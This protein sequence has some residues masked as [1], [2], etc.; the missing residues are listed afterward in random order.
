MR[1][2]L[3]QVPYYECCLPLTTLRHD[4]SDSCF[5][6][7]SGGILC[8][9]WEVRTSCHR[10][11]NQVLQAQLYLS[12]TTSRSLKATGKLWSNHSHLPACIACTNIYPIRWGCQERLADD[13]SAWEK[14]DSLWMNACQLFL[15]EHTFPKM[16]IIYFSKMRKLLTSTAADWS[17]GHLTER[18]FWEMEGKQS[19]FP[20]RI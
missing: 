6:G 15:K 5:T 12:S 10:S 2:F 19:N 4:F 16:I 7:G 9:M 14:K 18:I 20:T 3:R 17:L 8:C 11:G 1:Y 13:N